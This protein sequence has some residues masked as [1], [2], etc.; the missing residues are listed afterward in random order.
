[1]RTFR[2]CRREIQVALDDEVVVIESDTLKLGL[3]VAL[4]DEVVVIESDKLKL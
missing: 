2:A 4:D 1:M 3:V